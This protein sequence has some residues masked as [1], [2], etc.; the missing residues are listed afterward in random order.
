MEVLTKPQQTLKRTFS[1]VANV[2]VA[3]LAT[4]IAIL[5]GNATNH[6]WM[7]KVEISGIQTVAGQVDILLIK[8]STANAA[9]TS[10][11]MTVVPHDAGDAPAVSVPLS[12]TAN[13]TPGA[14]VGTIKRGYQAVAAPATATAAAPYAWEGGVVGKGIK[15]M[16]V[17]EG[18][19]INL[20]GV[21]VTGG[22]LSVRFEWREELPA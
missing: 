19:A 18:L 10:A 4:D 17:N 8:R 16:G 14:A 13:P 1:A 3:A 7:T 21:T 22:V 11:A 6:V 5:P 2:T 15:L 12:Y 20:N 9:G